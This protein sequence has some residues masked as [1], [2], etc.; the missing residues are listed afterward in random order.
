MPM[1]LANLESVGRLKAHKTERAEIQRLFAAAE[2][3]LRDARIEAISAGTRLDTAYKCI[4]QSALA[5]LLANG[6]RPSTNQPG[7]QQTTIQTLPLT[8]GITSERMRLLDAFRRARNLSDYEGDPIED[9]TARECVQAAAAL[10]GDVR[11]WIE[12]NRPDLV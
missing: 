11:A 7:H 9:A 10:L 2:V 3:A 5:A 12:K 1:S 4:M 8:T 6:Y